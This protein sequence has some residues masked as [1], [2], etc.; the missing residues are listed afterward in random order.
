M[1]EINKDIKNLE[2]IIMEGAELMGYEVVKW[3]YRAGRKGLLQIYIDKEGGITLEDCIRFNKYLNNIL[4]EKD[5]IPTSYIL[6]VSSPGVVRNLENDKDYEK[7]KNKWVILFTKNEIG[8]K[9]EFSGELIE[10][11]KD[12]LIIKEGGKLHK[13]LKKHILKARIDTPI[14]KKK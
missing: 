1:E 5:P 3:K 14:F 7:A 11:S 9:G 10:V 13:V 2:K 12:F 6:E 4:D 8:R